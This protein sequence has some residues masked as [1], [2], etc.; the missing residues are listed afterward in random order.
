[1]IFAG[2]DRTSRLRQLFLLLLL[3]G[4]VIAPAAS[5]S[6]DSG[7]GNDAFLLPPKLGL[8]TV[9]WPRLDSLEKEVREQLAGSQAT[10]ARVT[11]EP[12]TSTL[13]LGEAYGLMG[14]IYHAYSLHS[15]AEE[16]YVN[17]HRLAP[18]D[19][20]WVYL[21]GDLC[22]KLTRP[23]EA[24]NQYKL[25]RQL[26]PDY[27]AAA[28]KLG[29]LY[30]QQNRLEE[31]EASFKEALAIDRNCTAARYGLGQVALSAREYG[32]AV[33]Y[34]EQALKEIPAANRIHYSLAMAYRGAGNL[35]KARAHLVLRGSVGVRVLDPLVDGLT[36]LIQGER[37]H[38][39]R[40]RTALDAR[41]FSDAAEEFRK[42]LAS[43]PDSVPARVNLGTAL[44]E[45]GDI[46]GAIEQ[47]EETLRI[48]PAHAGA[49][50]N[51]GL[52]LLAQNRFDRAVLHLKTAS[53]LNPKDEEPRIVLARYLMSANRIDEAISEYAKLVESNP[54]NEDILMRLVGIQIS[55][56]RHADA[57]KA[58]NRGNALF[59][60]KGRT[61]ITLA[62]LLAASP[63]YDLR[64]GTRGLELAESVYKST[65]LVNH[66]AIVAMALAE[67][68][69]CAEAA[70]WQ[71]RMI[72]AAE[73]EKQSDLAEVFKIDLRRYE[74][75]SPCRPVDATNVPGPE[76]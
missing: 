55:Q 56:N 15:S 39:A 61:A 35:E 34:L 68:G 74:K 2:E 8:L 27:L 13:K 47:F 58:L 7:T 51:L 1:M 26:R 42:A 38:M 21:L 63:H 59:P 31:A 5:Q 75:G 11:K 70:E 19:F 24:I 46:E 65:G 72:A 44:A 18:D 57:L 40:G 48:D 9:H 45:A 29:D 20:R 32:I 60:E 43:R 37:I 76:K 50:Y 62:Y 3:I 73:R 66:G 67:L 33:S 53:E 64:N 10:L 25:A 6:K 41:R 36:D 14:Q 17:A 71:R 69:R 23:A 12:G 30:L 22:E 4:T 54:A 52:V 16:C 28:V 49:H